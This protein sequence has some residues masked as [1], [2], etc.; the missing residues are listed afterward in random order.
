MEELADP[1]LASEA[2]KMRDQYF[3]RI[4]GSPASHRRLLLHFAK[5]SKPD[6]KAEEI[7]HSKLSVD[8]KPLGS[9]SHEELPSF[10]KSQRRKF[11]KG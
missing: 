4:E 1:E 8:V 9:P 7:Q 11:L 5:Q 10:W 2:A 3:M 6:G